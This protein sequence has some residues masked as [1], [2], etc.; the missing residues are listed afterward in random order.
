MKVNWDVSQQFQLR[1]KYLVLCYIFGLEEFIDK[2]HTGWQIQQSRLHVYWWEHMVIQATAVHYMGSQNHSKSWIVDIKHLDHYNRNKLSSGWNSFF[3][4]I[5]VLWL[6]N[7]TEQRTCLKYCQ[8]FAIEKCICSLFNLGASAIR[9]H[10]YCWLQY[11]LQIS[12]SSL[13]LKI[14]IFQ[15]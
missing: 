8:M 15:E 13:C 2:T 9:N 14:F 4:L 5:S 10:P 6:F 11:A 1:D 7:Q 12:Q 3:T